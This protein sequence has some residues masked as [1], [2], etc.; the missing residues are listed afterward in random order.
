MVQLVAVASK[1][2]NDPETAKDLV[3]EIFTTLLTKR[4]DLV[5]IVSL[6]AY[7]YTSLKHA[8]FNHYRKE[9]TNKRY[10][11]FALNT[12][13][14]SDDSL[15]SRLHARELEEHLA[16]AIETLPP[17]C[18][19]VFKLSRQEHLSNSQIATRLQISENTV[20][21]HMRKA[22]RILRVSLG[23]FLQIGLILFP[24]IR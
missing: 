15:L 11:E 20:E 22:L 14:H 17:Q 8:I 7:L 18:K 4:D 2:I 3:Q 6:K 13:L 5:E 10:E 12:S 23:E 21:Q 24:F 1:K 19:T 16:E 9:L